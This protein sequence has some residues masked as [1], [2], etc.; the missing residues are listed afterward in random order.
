MYAQVEG[1]PP[2]NDFQN[3]K[4]LSYLNELQGKV[5]DLQNSKPITAATV[6]IYIPLPTEDSL[7]GA[8][9]TRSNGDFKFDRLPSVDT[10][11]VVASF[12]G[13]TNV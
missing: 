3:G 5:I 2:R 4:T 9:L 11:K 7:I 12:V 6:Q 8:M 13:H 1:V 10:L